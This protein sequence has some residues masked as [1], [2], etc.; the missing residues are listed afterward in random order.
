MWGHR[1]GWLPPNGTGPVPLVLDLPIT[2]E[3]FGSISD[4]SINGRLYFP[5]DG[6]ETADLDGP[7]NETADHKVREY[8]SVLVL[9]SVSP[10]N[11]LY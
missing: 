6:P 10:I 8:H 9:E 1:V 5:N 11:P 3:K 2:H 4:P 7:L